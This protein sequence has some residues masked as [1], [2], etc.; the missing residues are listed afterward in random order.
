M[1]LCRYLDEGDISV[2]L[3][4]LFSIL[5]ENM[6][7][8]APTGNT[9]DADYALWS[10]AVASAMQLENRHIVLIFSDEILIGYLQYYTND[11]T[12]MIEEAQLQSAYHGRG[13]MRKAFTFLADRIPKELPLIEAYANKKN[14]KS[15][16][17]LEHLG[18]ACIGENKNGNSCLYR[19]DCHAFFNH[20]K[21]ESLCQST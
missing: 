5:H 10:G 2:W 3:P 20:L 8:I 4:R 16:Q 12:L 6:N 11:T 15:Q 21:G 18:F 14:M 13:V 7:V 1:I 17:I 19:M 9:Y